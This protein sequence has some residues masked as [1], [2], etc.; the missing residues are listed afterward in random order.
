MSL[1]NLPAPS[2]E[3]RLL[4]ELSHEIRT[5]LTALL[6]YV[7]LLLDPPWSAE[8]SPHKTREALLTVQRSGQHVL[9]LVSGVLDWAC[10]DSAAA[11]KLMP[12]SPQTLCQEV[13]AALA[14]SAE[15]RGVRL[16]FVNHASAPV[17][18]QSDASRLR[19]I[20]FNLLGNALK[21]TPRGEIR[22]EL[23]GT[24]RERPPWLQI[25]VIDT[26]V[27]MSPRQ[28]ERLFQPFSPGESSASGAG[29]GLA[30][31]HRLC[32][33]MGGRLTATSALGRGSNFCVELPAV[34]TALD[35]EP[36]CFVPALREQSLS[37]LRVLLAEDSADT[38]RILS[39]FLR[40]AGAI[41][42]EA[43]DGAEACDLVLAGDRDF[44]VVLLD[45]QMPNCDGL[46]ATQRLRAAGASVPI[47]ALTGTTRLEDLQAC[48]AAGCNGCATK[49]IERSVLIETVLRF[50]RGSREQRSLVPCSRHEPHKPHDRTCENSTAVSALVDAGIP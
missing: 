36:S 38:R 21:F 15:K 3:S 30:I 39:L 14:S 6:G 1:P 44:N 18:I 47:V 46:T 31:S 34:E 35:S 11:P 45:L 42:V 40:Q 32:K 16:R 41:V 7:E 49:P 9:D 37:G 50:A 2:A 27:G 22:V 5:P 10:A 33:A 26:G 19:Q 24:D 43:T 29:L 12:V 28:L 20:L 17:W 25:H 8:E 13:L 48:L 4:G 23:E